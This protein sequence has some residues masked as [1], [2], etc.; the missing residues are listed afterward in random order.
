MR[1]KSKKSKKQKKNDYVLNHPTYSEAL[2]IIYGV[3]SSI[4]FL[5]LN[6]FE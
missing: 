6:S 4:L 1:K 3:I 5:I 2:V